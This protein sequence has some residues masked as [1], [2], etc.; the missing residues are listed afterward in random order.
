MGCPAAAAIEKHRLAYAE[1][2][3]A[4]QETSAAEERLPEEFRDSAWIPLPVNVT[5]DTNLLL[6]VGARRSDV[7]EEWTLNPL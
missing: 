4:Y 3:A 6:A 5:P 1:M 7:A 2:K